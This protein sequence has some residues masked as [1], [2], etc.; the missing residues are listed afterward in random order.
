M[1]TGRPSERGFKESQ[2]G[3]LLLRR[4]KGRTKMI[5]EAA[6]IITG[7][8][9]NTL[10]QKISSAQQAL[11]AGAQGYLVKPFEAESILF[12]VRRMLKA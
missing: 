6:N 9:L 7:S 5:S 2:L 3:D 12:T 10:S 8:Y 4:E 11:K 1:E